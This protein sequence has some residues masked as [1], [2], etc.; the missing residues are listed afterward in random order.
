LVGGRDWEE[1]KE[2]VSLEIL[3][4]KK[5]RKVEAR[6]EVVGRDEGR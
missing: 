4:L 1:E 3:P 5:E 6:S 2:E